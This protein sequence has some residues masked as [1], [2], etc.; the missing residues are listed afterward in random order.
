MN[1]F[2]EFQKGVWGG[3]EGQLGA[4]RDHGT[5][6][7]KNFLNAAAETIVTATTWVDGRVSAAKVTTGT[8]ALGVDA[9]AER[10]VSDLREKRRAAA[11][12]A[13]LA[14]CA[15][16]FSTVNA[17]LQPLIAGNAE[18]KSVVDRKINATREVVA[19]ASDIDS[20]KKTRDTAAAYAA[21][22]QAGSRSRSSSSRGSSSG[23]SQTSRGID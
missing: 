6:V 10:V 20:A 18:L 19:A 16:A 3:M 8:G 12:A 2:D 23:I 13:A 1:A 17:S 15:S 22:L 5:E 21:S 7:G 14:V 11:A 9:D 4:I